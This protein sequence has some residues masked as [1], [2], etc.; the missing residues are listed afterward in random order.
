VTT[1]RRPYGSRFDHAGAANMNV[2]IADDSAVVR[3]QLS[4]ILTDAG[5]DV[6]AASNG[7]EAWAE[8]CTRRHE[9]AILD[10]LMPG[11]TGPDICRRL[12]SNEALKSIYVLILTAK[13]SREDVAEALIAGA[14]DYVVKPFD[15]GELLA[16]LEVAGRI[17][18]LQSELAEATQLAAVGR[19]SAGI[20]HEINT[21]LQY[22]GDNVNFLQEGF[23]GLLPLVAEATRFCTNAASG[24]TS[25][26][27][28]E[29]LVRACRDA[30]VDY[31]TGEIPIAVGQSLEGVSH[32]TAIVKA[33]KEF[34]HPGR[35]EKVYTDINRAI[36]VTITIARN[37]WKYVADV[38]TEL[39]PDLP[40]VLCLA[41]DINQ[42]LLNLIVNA[43]HA[44]GDVV[45]EARDE[46][47]SIV[48]STTRINGSVEIRVRD[49]GCGIPDPVRDRLFDPFFTT[50]EAGKGT[51]QGLAIVRKVVDDHFGSIEFETT[52]GVGSTFIIRLP[53]DG[54]AEKE[55]VIQDEPSHTVC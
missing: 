4:D 38:T 36:D 1:S 10:W 28:V 17:V 6:W 51:G 37:E 20:A 25:E 18:R 39:D 29:L 16:R 45:D 13:S 32:V 54:D 2:L 23:I 55:G 31:L 3:R 11:L 21:P 46:K 49:T 14:S 48:V 27:P 35:R 44:V 53:I 50:K 15:R 24:E 33:M 7:D 5:H 26:R 41:G 52:V 8:L 19:L 42:V 22:I 34:C 47:G 43:A 12:Q 9:V 40:N 30:D